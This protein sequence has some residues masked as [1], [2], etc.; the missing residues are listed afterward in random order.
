MTPN[1]SWTDPANA[2]SYTYQFQL[3]DQNGTRSGRYQATTPTP[4]AS[5]VPSPR[6]P[7]TSIR[8]A[9]G[10]LPN[11]SSLNGNSEL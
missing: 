5:P 1:F 3:W 7:G 11:V 8:Q 10:D 2:S 4:T 6:L 9:S